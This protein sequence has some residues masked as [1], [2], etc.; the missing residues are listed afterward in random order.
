MEVKYQTSELPEGKYT[1]VL[2]YQKRSC[3]NDLKKTSV[4]FAACSLS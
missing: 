1:V 3:K 2:H 4:A